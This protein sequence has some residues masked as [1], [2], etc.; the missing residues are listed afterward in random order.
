METVI[1]YKAQDGKLFTSKQDCMIYNLSLIDWNLF[2]GVYWVHCVWDK[3]SHKYVSHLINFNK[4]EYY[5]KNTMFS[6]L[7]KS[8][9]YL[10][11]PNETVL[12]YFINYKDYFYPVDNF[13]IRNLKAGINYLCDEGDSK[14]VCNTESRM[15]EYREDIREITMALEDLEEFNDSIMAHI[16]SEELKVMNDRG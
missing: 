13:I 14:S 10:F 1:Q 5:E 6:Q 2:K 11:V 4:P 15:K 9:Y 7:S 12:K 8:D 3:E 16:L